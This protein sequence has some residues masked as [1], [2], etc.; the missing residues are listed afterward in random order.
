MD[1]NTSS[2][3]DSFHL[4]LSDSEAS[5]DDEQSGL[6]QGRE[7]HDSGFC[8][9]EDLSSEADS[10]T[11]DRSRYQVE[12]EEDGHRATVSSLAAEIKALRQQV[13]SQ[14]RLLKELHAVV[15]AKSRTAQRNVVEELQG[16]NTSVRIGDDEH[17]IV[18]NRKRFLHVLARVKCGQSLLLKTMSLV[19]EGDELAGFSFNGDRTVDP[20]LSALIDDQRFKAISSQVAK[21]YPRYDGPHEIR[22]LRDTV[23]GKCH[24]VLDMATRHQCIVGVVGWIDMTAPGSEVDAELERLSRNPLFLGLRH[25]L[26]LEEPGWIERKDV[27]CTLGKLEKLNLTFD[28]LLRPHTLH[29]ANEIATEFPKLRLIINHLAKPKIRDREFDSWAEEM[30]RAAENPNVFVKLSGMV[31]EADPENWKPSDLKPYVHHC[32]KVFGAQRCVFGSDYPVFKMVGATYQQVYDALMECLLDCTTQEE[33]EG[34]FGE[35]A[36]AFYQIKTA[37]QK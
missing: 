33:Q 3:S 17:G 15:I 5:S 28:L 21:S 14:Q 12:D 27:R 29:Y 10:F 4:H 13:D 26:D 7:R 32:V 11:E 1:S 18:V 16:N 35:N 25:I 31:T 19:Y 34:I 20:P 24:W 8:A 6:V 22:I 37:L 9:E 23:N 30:S 36:I 2:D